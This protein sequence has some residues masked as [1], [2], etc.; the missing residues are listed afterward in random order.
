MSNVEPV[1]LFVSPLI[2]GFFVTQ[3]VTLKYLSRL[4]YYMQVISIRKNAY[5]CRSLYF[6]PF[7]EGVEDDY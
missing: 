6:K 2:Y 5:I 4:P 1:T 3:N 7:P